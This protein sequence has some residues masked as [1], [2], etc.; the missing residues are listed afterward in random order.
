MKPK[1]EYTIG[2]ADFPPFSAVLFF[3]MKLFLHKLEL[4]NYLSF[5]K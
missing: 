1:S 5:Q 3:K 4:Q 2:T